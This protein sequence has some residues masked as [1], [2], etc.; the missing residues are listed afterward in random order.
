M[1]GTKGVQH[2]ADEPQSSGLRSPE[3]LASF[4][5]RAKEFFAGMTDEGKRLSLAL[6][7]D[8]RSHMYGDNTSHWTVLRAAGVSDGLMGKVDAQKLQNAARLFDKMYGE[9]FFEITVDRK[10]GYHTR[11]FLTPYGRE[12]R[13]QLSIDLLG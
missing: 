2:S 5:S 11:L 9:G 6:L 12:A 7:D 10:E 3:E 4:M 13:L 1:G 8:V